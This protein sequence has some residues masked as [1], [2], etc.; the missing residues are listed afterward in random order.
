MAF[1]IYLKLSSAVMNACGSFMIFWDAF[2]SNCLGFLLVL[3]ESISLK[4]PESNQIVAE[5]TSGTPEGGLAKDF[6]V[7]KSFF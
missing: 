5:N 2:Q 1:T 3:S 7:W 6:A 4:N